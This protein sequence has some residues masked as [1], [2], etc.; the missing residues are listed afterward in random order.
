MSLAAKLCAAALPAVQHTEGLSH[1]GSKRH[2]RPG[3]KIKKK[4]GRTYLQLKTAPLHKSTSKNKLLQ[5]KK[6]SSN[7]LR[8]TVPREFS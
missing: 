3:R 1:T 5:G 7:R 2:E 8:E 4:K 6:G